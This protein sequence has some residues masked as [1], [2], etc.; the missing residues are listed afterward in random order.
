MAIGGNDRN[1]IKGNTI[2]NVKAG[3][4]I[5]LDAGGIDTSDDN[6]VQDNTI[7]S[8]KDSGIT[9]TNGKRVVI[10]G[11][12]INQSGGNG[13]EVNSDLI[14]EGVIIKKNSITNSN[15]DGIEIESG[16]LNTVVI[17]NT[18]AE[19]GNDNLVDNG[20]GTVKAGNT[21]SLM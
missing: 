10:Q 13:I 2:V 15:G 11:N 19:N 8:S 3:R 5:R 21:P 12:T 20:T 9:V 18:L 7:I 6:Q 16:S 4:G 1:I 17:G 14:S